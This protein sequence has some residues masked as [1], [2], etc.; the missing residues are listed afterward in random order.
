MK[1][2]QPDLSQFTFASGSDGANITGACAPCRQGQ[3][4]RCRSLER[5][6]ESNVYPFFE[7]EDGQPREGGDWEC[8]CLSQSTR[9][10]DYAKHEGVLE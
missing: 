8:E 4:L 9:R 3:H 10:R 6:Q 1:R 7:P 2:Q 5:N